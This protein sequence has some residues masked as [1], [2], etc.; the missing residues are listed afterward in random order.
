MTVT[1]LKN[2]KK[3][4]KGFLNRLLKR[5]SDPNKRSLSLRM[6]DVIEKIGNKLPHPATLFAIFALLTLIFSYIIE[7]MG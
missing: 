1:K 3:P 2:D 5:S 7:R 4:L 6:L